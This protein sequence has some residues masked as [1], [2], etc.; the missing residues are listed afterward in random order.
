MQ[1][2]PAV[3]V[4]EDDN[5][6]I[7]LLGLFGTLID[8]KWLIAAVT[9]AFMLT[10]AAY[11]VLATPVYQAN[12]LLQVEAKK[13]DLLGF[14]DIGGML[15]KES[16]S[17][18]EIELI[19][20]R[21]V[22]GK[23]VDNLKLD[24]VVQPMYFPV[25]GEFLARRF[26]KTNPGAIA[27]PLL[28]LDSFAWGGES[29]KIFKLD[30]PDGQLGKKLTLTV[31]EHDHFT[32][33]DEDDQVLAAGQ[34]GQLIEQN[35]VAFQIEEL[36]AKPGTRFRVIRNARLTSILDYQENLDVVERGKE[37]GMIGL[38][39]ES[40][41]PDQ[42]IKILNQIAAIYVRQNVERTSA[43]A[44]QSLAFLKEQLPE[45][46][47][48]LEKA[49]KALNEY[50]TRSKSVDITL[51]TKAILDQIVGLDTSISELKLQQAEMD[52]KF[53]RQHPAYRALLTQIGELTSKQQS[54]AS[55]V[56][57]LPSTQQELLSLT[58]DV[59]VG[60]AIYT[61]LLNKSQELDVMRAGTVGNVRLIDTADVNYFK[62]IK[63]KKI[64][65]V[66]IATL[67]GGFLAVALVL[68]RKA[69]N[70]G[71]ESPEAIEQL[72]LPVYASIPYSPLQKVEEDKITRG[73]GRT[74]AESSLL[75]IS[76]PTDLAVEAL[77]SLRTSLHFAMLE[78]PNNRIMISGP[79]P[80]VGKTFVSVNLA[81]VIAQ[82]GQ[83]VLLIDVD[84]RRG[85]LHKVL[86][87]PA[88]DGL[89]DILSNQ[90]TLES[91]IHKTGIENLDIISRG[92]IPPNPS[93]LLMHRNL[94]ELLSQVSERYDLVILD[95]P[96]LLAVTDAAIVGRQSG[97]NL[98]VTRYGL[99]PAKEIE[100]T[101]RR[102]A[103]NGIV[104]RGAIFNGVEKKASAKYGYGNYGYYQYEYQADRS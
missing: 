82:T 4:R 36:R 79:S 25:V 68:L 11:A 84:M 39:L 16:P 59:E 24:I 66:L 35:G 77:R 81:A 47:K 3:T 56:E 10:G 20:S 94:T 104:L 18:T 19:Q 60:T 67:L 100:H 21:Y 33:V 93:E 22:I 97:T 76:H 73:R 23:T 46:K 50:Q 65:I 85:Y 38:A 28:G 98:I 1:Q 78:A 51:E 102:F 13:N 45:V 74:N 53:T 34:V 92:Q 29:L 12:A 5:E 75:A 62:P 43:E 69:L 52:R 103:Q 95:T 57:G 80:E 26:Q 31:G 88:K 54:L 99:N 37:S 7:D 70:R 89:S 6:E 55:R 30:L 71:L 48:D 83:R 49:G 90:C 17:A 64:L 72:G 40:T 44:A 27:E 42:A 86:G 91:A 96:P 41:D 87:V 63:P 15:G 14:S 32:L 61:Q 2:A 8:H 9:G 58:R 101:I